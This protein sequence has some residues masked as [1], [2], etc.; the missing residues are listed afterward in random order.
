MSE[1]Q[2]QDSKSMPVHVVCGRFSS[3]V[4]V[5]VV[6]VVGWLHSANPGNVSGSILWEPEPR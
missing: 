6:L 2:R 4:V 3:V 5:V 1:T